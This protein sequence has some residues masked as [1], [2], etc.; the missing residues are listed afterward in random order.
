MSKNKANIL[1]SFFREQVRYS[2]PIILST[3]WNLGILGLVFLAIQI[4]TGLFL[5]INYG[6]ILKKINVI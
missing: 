1:I 6:L 5:V 4:L 2:T 3:A